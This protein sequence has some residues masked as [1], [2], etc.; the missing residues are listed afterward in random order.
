MTIAIDSQGL[1][2]VESLAITSTVTEVRAVMGWVQGLAS[3]AALVNE[4][5]SP[6]TMIPIDMG[7]F[8]RLHALESS[9]DPAVKAAAV[10]SDQLCQSIW[11]Y[12]TGLEPHAAWPPYPGPRAGW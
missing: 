12:N 5:P 10:W 7:W 1:L 2:D 11:T 4:S 9:A 6:T 8:M 3:Q